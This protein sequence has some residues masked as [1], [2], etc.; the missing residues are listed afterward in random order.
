LRCY[1]EKYGDAMYETNKGET[2]SNEKGSEA[3]YSWQAGYSVHMASEK[4]GYLGRGEDNTKIIG[5]GIFAFGRR[6]GGVYIFNS[7]RPTII[8]E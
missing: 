1:E 5:K 3:T 4:F 7:F 2:I 8:I 6:N